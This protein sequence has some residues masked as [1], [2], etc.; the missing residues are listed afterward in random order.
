MRDKLALTIAL[1]GFALATAL[2]VGMAG[3]D[4]SAGLGEGKAANALTTVPSLA[5]P[6]APACANQIDDDGDGPIDLDD[7][8]C[9]SAEDTSEEA[10][11]PASEGGDAPTS[12]A[13]AQPGAASGKVRAGAT[14]DAAEAEE[15]RGALRRNDSIDAPGATGGG[16]VSAPPATAGDQ[17]QGPGEDGGSRFDDGGS[18]SSDNPTTTIAPFGPAPIGVPNLVIDSFEIPPFLLPIYQACGTQYGI[19][20]Q[21]LAS[22]NKIETAFGT[23]LNVSSAGA[24]GW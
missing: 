16:G 24:M 23:N 20:W 4:P 22:I 11:A 12:T 6:E 14:L 9:E 21:V 7:P 3:A 19:P 5:A 1:A 2:G 18:P 13:P 17:P 15:A 10:G 8:D